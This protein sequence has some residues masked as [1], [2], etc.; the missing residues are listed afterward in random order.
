MI[1]PSF[2]DIFYSNCTKNGL[3]PVI[4]D[5]AECRMVAGSG[6]ARVD[7]DDQTVNCAEGVFHFEIDEQIKHRLVNGLDDVAMTLERAEKIDAFEAGGGGRL[8]PGHHGADDRRHADERRSARL[9]RRDLRP[10]LATRSTSGAG[11]ARAARALRAT[12]P[13]STPAAARA[14]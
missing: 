12:R 2:S 9:G 7:L 14:A 8:G 10:R 6:E 13:C 1:A 4:L 5:E 11:G 3:L